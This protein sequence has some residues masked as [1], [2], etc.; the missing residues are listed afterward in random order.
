MTSY[1]RILDV[2]DDVEE[3]N[4]DK[5][6]EWLTQMTVDTLGDIDHS[7]VIEALFRRSEERRNEQSKT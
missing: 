3:L 6:L 2:F 7:D 1:K 5:S 4:P